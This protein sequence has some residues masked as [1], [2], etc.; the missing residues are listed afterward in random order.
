MKNS[1]AF[2]WFG[3][4]FQKLLCLNLSTAHLA[5]EEIYPIHCTLYTV[6]GVDCPWDN[7]RQ[8]ADSPVKE[9]LSLGKYWPL[10]GKT[11]KIWTEWC[12]YLKTIYQTDK[13]LFAVFP[14][15]S[16]SAC[17]LWTQQFLR[18]KKSFS[19]VTFI[20]AWTGCIS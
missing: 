13:F 1:F 20:K 4:I 12:I 8:P 19:R 16:N 15:C 10:V 18:R 11:G 7:V 2:I 3:L 5:Q 14:K 9:L 6:Q 17:T